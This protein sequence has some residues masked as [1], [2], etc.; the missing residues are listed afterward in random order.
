LKDLPHDSA[1]EGVHGYGGTIQSFLG[2]F[3]INQQPHVHSQIEAILDMIRAASNDN[4]ARS[5]EL[6]NRQPVVFG[7]GRDLALEA[8]LWAPISIHILEGTRLEDAFQQFARKLGITIEV[9][10]HGALLDEQIDDDLPVELHSED[11]PANKAL[12]RMLNALQLEAVAR[13]STLFVTT[14]IAVKEGLD[15]LEVRV[16]RCGLASDEGTRGKLIDLLKLTPGTDWDEEARFGG[17]IASINGLLVIRQTPQAHAKIE[18]TLNE[19]H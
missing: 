17:R 5:G 9:D 13:S 2:M 3:V 19:V 7:D 8:K 14:Q 18:E 12:D 16:Y 6:N 10:W 1:W 11:L 15:F 4:K